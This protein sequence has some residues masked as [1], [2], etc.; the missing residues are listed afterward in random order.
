MRK[1]IVSRHPAAIE[2]VRA[3]RPDFCDAEVMESVTADD[4]RGAHVVGNL[5]MSLA[6]LCAR[7]EAIEFSGPPPRGAEYGLKEMRA[8]GARLVE[9]RVRPVPPPVDG[10][11]LEEVATATSSNSPYA[12]CV[13]VRAPRGTVFPSR[14]DWIDRGDVGRNR[15]FEFA[16]DPGGHLAVLLH[17][18]IREARGVV[19]AYELRGAHES[20][21]LAF[22][23]PGAVFR[24]RT[25]YKC[26]RET[27]FRVEEGGLEREDPAVLAEERTSLSATL[28]ERLAALREE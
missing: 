27:I 16:P 2:F 13:R 26:R 6:A 11:E 4:V 1:I 20:L 10:S 3:E 12:Y 23:R 25:G 28:A 24:A 8:C 18:E 22:A 14:G 7:Y 15:V 21:T 17:G 5:P 9:Y 19:V